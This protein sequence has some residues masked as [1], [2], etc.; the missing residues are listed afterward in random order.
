MQVDLEAVSDPRIRERLSE[1]FS[2]AEESRVSWPEEA[3]GRGA[4]WIVRRTAMKHGIS[5]FTSAE[6]ELVSV[7]GSAVTLAV[8]STAEVSPQGFSPSGPRVSMVMAGS[9][10]TT[11]HLDSLAMTAETG[12]TTHTVITEAGRADRNTKVEAVVTV[13]STPSGAESGIR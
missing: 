12:I 10:K 13:T 3:V 11:V 7:Q 8:M 5:V 1:A 9:G 6:Y 4:R 2:S